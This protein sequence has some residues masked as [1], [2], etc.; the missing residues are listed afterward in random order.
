MR[1]QDLQAITL[2]V[3][4]LVVE[5]FFSVN[6][7]G[8]AAPV[9][10]RLT[11][12]PSANC[13]SAKVFVNWT[14]PTRWMHRSQLEMSHSTGSIVTWST[15]IASRRR[16]KKRKSETSW[17]SGRRAQRFYLETTDRYVR[18]T[19]LN[20]YF[21]SKCHFGACDK[22]LIGILQGLFSL[23]VEKR[24]KWT[25]WLSR[26]GTIIWIREVSV[27]VTRA[28]KLDGNDDNGVGKWKEWG[29]YDVWICWGT[30]WIL[31]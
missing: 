8:P 22:G 14:A 12:M 24:R 31:E 11:G 9:H 29:V 17:T 19:L 26:S 28:S 15:T 3:T 5:P 7:T 6:V 20:Q 21:V 10:V 1:S 13:Q 27:R 23:E 2:T 4:G 25:K 16:K 18:L 30:Y